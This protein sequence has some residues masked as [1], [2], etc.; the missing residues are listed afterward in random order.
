MSNIFLSEQAQKDLNKLDKNEKEKIK[1]NLFQLEHD[2]KDGKALTGKL[3]GLY[4]LKAWPYRIIYFI[5]KDKTIWV[6]HIMH[7]KDVYR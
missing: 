6:V 1:R 3:K 2:T 5:K 7:R 4:S